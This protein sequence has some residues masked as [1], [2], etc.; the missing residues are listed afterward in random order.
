VRGLRPSPTAWLAGAFALAG[1]LLGAFLGARQLA[2]RDSGLDRLEYLTLD[3]R[4]LLAGARPAPRAVVIAAI[5]DEALRELGSYPVP[6]DA[7][8]RITR[9]LRSHDPQAI[10][11]DMLFADRRDAEADAALAEALRAGRSAI[12]AVGIFEQDRE[13]QPARHDDPLPFVPAPTRVL[14]PI[15]A[16]AAAART[17]LVNVSTDPSGVP[18]FVPMLFRRPDVSDAIAPSL[19]LALATAALN[20]EPSFGTEQVRLAGRAVPL[21]LGHHLPIRFYGPRGSIRQFSVARLLRHDLD[22]DLVRGQVVLIG[23][24][25]AGMGDA[26]ATPFDRLV[27]GVEI[28]ATALSNVLAGDGLARTA[29]TRRADAAA[30]VVLPLVLVLLL[31]MRRLMLGVGLAAVVILAWLALVHAAFLSGV[32]LALA[33]PLAAALPAAAAF[34]LV[35]LIRE[36]ARAERLDSEAAAIGKFQSPLLRQHLRA[37]PDFLAAPAEQDA[38]VVFLDLSG[39]TGVAEAIGPR[40]TRDLLAEFQ[41]RIERD[42]AAH[43]GY[44]ASFAGDGA[45]ILFGVPQPRPDDAARALDAMAR[46]LGTITT[47]LA[48]L[49]PA[50]RDR[51]SI[52][53]GGHFGPVVLS[54]LGG[55]NHQHVAAT[56]DTVNVASR[57]LEIARGLQSVALVTEELWSAAEPARD[58]VAAGAPQNVPVRGRARGLTVRALRAT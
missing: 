14:W 58:A 15:D 3:W 33:T 9:E 35:R 19:V 2:G 52:R 21:D 38:A 39:F 41:Q 32:W 34:A 20:T 57:L 4:Y 48:A 29:L 6:R 46:L 49:P 24:T 53:I 10:G 51:L 26:F 36:R 50:A 42:V 47:W 30:S 13:Q 5:D 1:L 11:L 27:P 17:G 54:R 37:H 28:L 44:V 22:P 12:G 40:W 56:G 31:A 7:L 8:A 55:A 23:A 25:A 43:E 45:M 16:L 18:R